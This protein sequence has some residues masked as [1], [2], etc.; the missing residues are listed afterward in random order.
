MSDRTSRERPT[1]VLC[2]DDHQ[3]L[4]EGLR[5]KLSLEPDMEFVGWIGSA[6]TLL[7]EVKS[8]QADVVLLDIEMPGPDPFEA[9]ADLMRRCPTCGSSC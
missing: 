5:T 1:R 9:L 4:G 7:S 2:V 8:T 6:E 3:F